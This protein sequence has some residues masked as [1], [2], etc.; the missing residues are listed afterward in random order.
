M[1]PNQQFQYSK[2]EERTLGGKVSGFPKARILSLSGAPAG[3]AGY[4]VGLLPS[5]TLNCPLKR[6]AFAT[7]VNWLP[8]APAALG[9]RDGQL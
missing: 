9:D 5:T 1:Q 3:L 4:E 7:A 2:R 8:L 6:G